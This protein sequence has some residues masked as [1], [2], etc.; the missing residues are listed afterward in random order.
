MKKIHLLT[1]VLLLA[2]TACN[3]AKKEEGTTAKDS[4]TQQ[5]AAPAPD[6]ATMMKNWQAYMTPGDMHKMMASWD[7]N[8]SCTVSSW[9]Q[10]GTP[11]VTS[12]A[13]A[14]NKMVLGGRYQASTFTGSFNGMPFEGMGT[15]AYDN[16]KKLFIS[17]WVDNMGTGVMK[18]EG[19]WDPAK[20]SMELKGTMVDPSS[21]KDVTARETFTEKDANTQVMTMFAPGPDGKEFKTM[22]IIFTR[23]K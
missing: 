5:A 19:P 2:S 6:S 10:P 13:T 12:K 11:P 14:V 16:A 18:M 17:T 9:M 3:N 23:N 8:W 20:K 7:G 4:S 21:G 15:L 1:T 22:E